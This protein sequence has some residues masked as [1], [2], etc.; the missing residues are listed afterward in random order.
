MKITY[1]RDL[2]LADSGLR[3]LIAAM[4][5]GFRFPALPLEGRV[6]SHLG[7]EVVRPVRSCHSEVYV[8]VGG[9]RAGWV[10]AFAS[11]V[12]GEALCPDSVEM[13]ASMHAGQSRVRVGIGGGRPSWVA[14]LA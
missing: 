9:G 13:V 3:N 4:R 11:P 7:V 5:P 2:L 12:G 14:R 8:G 6:L 1:L 10:S